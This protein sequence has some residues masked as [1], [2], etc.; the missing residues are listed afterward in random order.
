MLL[1]VLFLVD[2]FG[3]GVCCL[4]CCDCLVG[5][6]IIDFGVFLVFV[7]CDCCFLGCF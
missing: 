3:G 7:Y 5:L 6:C 2:V 1:I 4:A